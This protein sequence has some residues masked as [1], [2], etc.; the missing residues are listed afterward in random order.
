[1]SATQQLRAATRPTRL[2]RED[3]GTSNVWPLGSGTRGEPGSIAS[4]LSGGMFRHPSG[5]VTRKGAMNGRT[6]ATLRAERSRL[7]R[8]R[9]ISNIS[10]SILTEWEGRRRV[11]FGR[12]FEPDRISRRLRRILRR[13]EETVTRLGMFR[14]RVETG[15]GDSNSNPGGLG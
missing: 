5:T 12:T 8:S 2:R 13:Y 14:D 11:E 10:R 3:G 6:R 1:M 4:F 9:R 15:G 7:R